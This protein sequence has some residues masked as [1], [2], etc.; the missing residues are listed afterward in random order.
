MLS[1]RI[2]FAI[3]IASIFLP[4]QTSPTSVDSAPTP[5]AGTTGSSAEHGKYVS[6][7]EILSRGGDSDALGEYP[8][9]VLAIVRKKWY[10]QIVDLKRSVGQKSGV[11]VIG[12]EINNDGSVGKVAAVESTGDG[13]LDGAAST[14][15]LSSAPFPHL[16]EAYHKKVLKI[17]MHFGY[18]QPDNAEARSCDGP[19]WGAH[20]ATHRSD[21]VGLMPP[22]PKYSP[23]PVYSE[24]ARREK[25]MSVV[26]IAGTAD[27]HGAFTDLCL[28]EAAGAGLDERAMEVVKTWRFEPATLRGGEPAAVR[29]LI[30]VKFRLY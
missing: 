16:P 26:G 20:G 12:F 17:R 10:P 25:Y 18:D 19:N 15:I 21:E 11:A 28:A 27:R 29:L 7:F 23:D 9:Q 8:Y 22:I 14:A 24:Q 13:S 5:K 30:E 2:A 3:L 4:G 1:F 6:G